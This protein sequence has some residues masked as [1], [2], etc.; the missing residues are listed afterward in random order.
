MLQGTALANGRCAPQAPPG[1]TTCIAQLACTFPAEK[2]AILES[3]LGMPCD[4][5]ATGHE[6]RMLQLAIALEPEFSWSL[7]LRNSGQEL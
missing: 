6:A 7:L 1:L 4:T 2:D 5:E 3:M